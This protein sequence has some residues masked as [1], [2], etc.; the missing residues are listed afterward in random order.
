MGSKKSVFFVLLAAL[1]SGGCNLTGFMDNPSNDDQYLSAARACLDKGDFQCA[2]DNYGKVSGAE[3]DVANSEIAMTQL[4]EQG[5]DMAAFMNFVADLGDQTPGYA[6]TKFA[7][8]LVP[9]AGLAKREAIWNAFNMRSQI[10]TPD[11]ANFV[12]FAGGLSLAG[13]LLAEG[14][15]STTAILSQSDLANNPSTCIAAGVSCAATAGCDGPT[16]GTG[17]NLTGAS[18]TPDITS[19]SPTNA[20]PSLDQVYQSINASITGLANLGATGRFSSIS[21][22]LSTYN[23]I[24]GGAAPS[25]GGSATVR[26]FRYALISINVGE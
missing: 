14:A 11:L 18:G 9:N 10:N 5:A 20:N 21:N 15:D 26:C 2:L 4:D 6:I 12:E 7:E 23:H 1:A 22:L 25:S 17:S 19:T 3:T 8:R 16:S 24:S 13:E